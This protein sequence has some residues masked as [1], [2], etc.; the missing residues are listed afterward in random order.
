MSRRETVPGFEANIRYLLR[1]PPACSGLV[2]C[3]LRNGW[4]KTALDSG[5]LSMVKEIYAKASR[6]TEGK[7]QRETRRDIPFYGEKRGIR[8]DSRQGQGSRSDDLGIPAARS[9]RR[10]AMAHKK[11][12]RRDNGDG[13]VFQKGSS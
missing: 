3:G 8:E 12:R 2:V 10:L 11:T 1:R 6:Q 13:S 5:I 7:G 9:A 4:R